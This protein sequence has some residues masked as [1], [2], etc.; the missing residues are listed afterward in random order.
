MKSKL[1]IVAGI[2]LLWVTSSYFIDK[3]AK[4]I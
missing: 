2:F 3:N 1:F 4:A